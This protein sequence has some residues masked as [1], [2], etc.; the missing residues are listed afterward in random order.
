MDHEFCGVVRNS[1]YSKKFQISA[2]N[3]FWEIY[4]VENVVFI[5][6][7]KGIFVEKLMAQI[8]QVMCAMVYDEKYVE[9]EFNCDYLPDTISDIV[10]GILTLNIVIYLMVVYHIV[11]KSGIKFHNKD[12]AISNTVIYHFIINLVRQ[13]GLLLLNFLKLMI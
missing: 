7:E 11:H 4:T 9:K 3:I 10:Q 2:I 8:I 5:R 6:K 12:L 1:G 13:Y